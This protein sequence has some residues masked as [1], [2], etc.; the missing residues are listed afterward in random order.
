MN[1]WDAQI[2]QVPKILLTFL[3]KGTLNVTVMIY[4]LLDQACLPQESTK[5]F[6]FTFF[7]FKGRGSRR[8]QARGCSLIAFIE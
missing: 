1:P 7:T 6:F 8:A 2:P 3:P 4:C 5:A